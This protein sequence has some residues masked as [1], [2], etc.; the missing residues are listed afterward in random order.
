MGMGTS[1]R[2]GRR[3][4]FCAVVAAASVVLACSSTSSSPMTPC[5]LGEPCVG[6]DACVGTYVLC[7]MIAGQPVSSCGCD[8]T[9]A[10]AGPG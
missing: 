5:V 7:G 9:D 6:S 8:A 1:E 10:G 4:L 3:A 2:R